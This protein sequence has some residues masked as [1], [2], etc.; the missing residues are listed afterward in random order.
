MSIVTS[1][2]SSDR[3]FVFLEMEVLNFRNMKTKTVY[4]IFLLAFLSTFLTAQEAI[5]NAG[6]ASEK[7]TV[8]ITIDGMACQEGCADTI[9]KNLKKT[10]GIYSA[11]VSYE[12]TEA[13]VQFDSNLVTETIV[14]KVIADTKVK[15][16]VYTVKKVVIKSKIE[17]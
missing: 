14:K 16:Y 8:T 15:D 1:I 10:E 2:Y 6:I 9:A 5:E 11:Q 17:E 13:I 12:T 4:L 3:K 7:I